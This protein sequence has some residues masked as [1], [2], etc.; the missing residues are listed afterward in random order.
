MGLSNGRT[1]KSWGTLAPVLAAM[2]LT[3]VG[4]GGVQGEP[5]A[6]P[7]EFAQGSYAEKVYAS[8]AEAAGGRISLSVRPLAS[9]WMKEIAGRPVNETLGVPETQVRMQ[10]RGTEIVS[11]QRAGREAGDEWLRPIDLAGF[12]RLGY[13]VEQGTYRL[14]GV[15]VQLDGSQS[16]HQALELCWAAQ[17]HCIVMDPVLYQLDAFAQTRRELLAQ[18]W[19]PVKELSGGPGEGQVKAMA[20]CTLNGYP[21]SAT[22]RITYPAYWVEYKNVFGMV[23]VRKDLGGQQAGVSC[24]VS[25]GQCL[26]SGFGY[27]NTSSCYGT[28][29]YTC[30]CENTGNLVGTTQP[31]TKSWSESKCSHVWAGTANV[32]WTIEGVGSGFSVQWNTNG[33]VD[34]NGGQIYDSC[35]W[36]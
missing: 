28:L 22:V 7:A 21:T 36:H 33:G 1:F 16:Q 13:P 9:G 23:L 34:S 12:E 11:L 30:D 18:G 15:D 10:S 8:Y 5:E 4:C 29:G 31:A 24:Y 17:G 3:A 26:S 35:S 32:S 19:K 27:S 20:V 14:L 25:N 2:S 6:P